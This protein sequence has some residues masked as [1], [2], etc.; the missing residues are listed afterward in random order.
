MNFRQFAFKNVIRNKRLYAGYFFSCTFLVMVF[1]VYSMLVFH[2]EMS[3]HDQGSYGEGAQTGMDVAQYIIYVF[4]FFFILYSM[5]VFLKL[6]KK[7]LGIC[8]VQGMSDIKLRLLVFL[9]NM[10]IGLTATVV[11]HCYRPSMDPG[12]DS[13]SNKVQQTPLTLKGIRIVYNCN[14]PDRMAVFRTG[15]HRLS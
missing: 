15:Y 13:G 4:S 2:P 8:I 12:D 1:F 6:R 7:E 11:G 10:M 14:D 3:L 5:G 9:E